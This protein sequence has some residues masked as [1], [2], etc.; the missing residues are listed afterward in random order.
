MKK[1]IRTLLPLLLCFALL[2]NVSAAPG[3]ETG[4]VSGK[5]DQYDDWLILTIDLGENSGV[6]NGQ[7]QLTFDSTELALLKAVG[8]D[9]WDV[10]SVNSEA[11]TLMFASQNAQNQGGTILS[12]YFV[13]TAEAES[14]SVSANVLLRND[15]QTVEEATLELTTGEISP[16]GKNSP[17]FAFEDLVDGEWYHAYTDYVIL[18]GIMKGID[19]NRFA[20]N[21]VVTRAMVVQTLYNMA[22]EPQVSNAS[23][24]ADVEKGAWYADA[25][26]WAQSVGIAKG[27][28]GSYFM[29][30]DP[31]TRQQA[32]AFLYR[33]Y[34]EC[35]NGTAADGADLTGYVDADQIDTYALEAMAWA[36][37]NGI[38]TGMRANR[39][40]PQRETTR[41]QLAKMLTV[42]DQIG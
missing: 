15:Q 29:P 16:E 32:A 24:F 41:A 26:A 42:L 27:V 12:V 19:S 23:S 10:E 5:L 39:L 34:L 8:S 17:S 36:N 30:N 18:S 3:E 14:Y 22:G 35:M 13:P 28:G 4:I 38:I 6:T 37:A 7:L 20:P 25:I 31:V 2:V 21:A 9:L 1:I 33:F 40:D 11:A